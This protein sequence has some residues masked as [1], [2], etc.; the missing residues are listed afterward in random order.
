MT[1]ETTPATGVEQ[2]PSVED[3][4]VAFYAKTPSRKAPEPEAPTEAAPE[5]AAEQPE[6]NPDA[7]ELTPEDIP[8]DETAA[9]A[10]PSGVD[11]FEIVHNGTQHKLNREETIR[12][13]QQG[14]DYTQKT[15]ALAEQN[16]QLADRLQRVSAIE[17]VHPQLKQAEAQVL[18]LQSQVQR[19]QSVDW[20]QLATNDPI[21]YSKVRAQYDVVNQTYQQ[22]R[23]QFEQL[24]GAVDEQQKVIRSQMLQ[25]EQA[26]LT[27]RIP[28]W[29]DPAKFKEGAQS[30]RSYLIAEGATPE[31]V[32]GLT[33]SMAVAIAWK[34]M[35]YD[36]LRKSKAEKVGQL[37]TAPPVTKPGAAQPIQ[38]TAQ[39]QIND[40]RATLKKTGDW[41]DAATLLAKMK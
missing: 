29:K 35:Q 8:D 22:A 5:V 20:V 16:R 39:R 4:L 1:A 28:E 19:Y 24:K 31:E 25:A 3:R 13:A 7:G 12:Y 14:F 17:Q 37:R 33:S 9:A 26:K 27:E 15:Q 34:A 23:G 41:R 32:D 6:V 2:A 10:E 11:V 40:A 18:A 36:K 30:L 21:E 38:S